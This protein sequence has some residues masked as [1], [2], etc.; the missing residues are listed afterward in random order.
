[1][2]KETMKMKAATETTFR[3]RARRGGLL[4]A[5]AGLLVLLAAAP[6]SAA[7]SWSIGM[8][9]KNLYGFGGLTSPYSGSGTSFARN[10]A[11]NGYSIQVTNSSL[12]VGTTL[13]CEN[14][15]W[16]G[17]T[18]FEYQWYRNSAPIA[19][20]TTSTYLTVAADVGKGLQCAVTGTNAGPGK[21][22]AY[23]APRVVG[24]PPTGGL[25]RRGEGQGLNATNS[26]NV[27]STLT[28]VPEFG[29]RWPTFTYQWL[30]NSAPIAGATNSTYT[31]QASDAPA[32]IQCAITATNAAG[33][34][35]V[36][37]PAQLTATA[38]SPT[39]PSAVVATAVA[40][41]VVNGPSISGGTDVAGGS[42]VGQKLTCTGGPAS[43]ATLAY[44]WLRNNAAI[45]GATSSTYTLV[46]A[47]AGT[48][49]Q[50]QVTATTSEAVSVK[51][52]SPLT[53]SP[54]PSTTP[55]AP[56]AAGPTVSGTANVGQVLTC[57]TG[58]WTGTSPTLTF[59][60][61][62]NGVAISGAT[63]STYTVA[64]SDLGANVQCQVSGENAG[65][66]ALQQSANKV[67][68][69]LPPSA[70]AAPTVSGTETVGGTLTCN[71][72][73]WAN[74]PSFGYEW[75]RNGAAISGATAQTYVVAIAD[76]GKVLQC[77]VT[78]ANS[79][80]TAQA[81]SA[82]TVVPPAPA[83]TPP[84]QSV[85]GSVSGTAE[86]GQVLTCA[87][88]TWSGGP[89]LSRQWLRNG[90]P[91]AGAIGETYTL[92]LADL[93]KSVQCQV[94]AANAGGASVAINATSGSVKPRRRRC[95]RPPR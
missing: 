69:A 72:G 6:A 61:L 9:H 34:V 30:K 62:H 25:P 83:T 7:P 53:V 11:G 23:T 76:E 91:I 79:Q 36:T 77:R 38:P 33:S 88:G 18:G 41:P 42:I 90:A 2:S 68:T 58:T 16:T 64:G 52:S 50:C 73:T 8:V 3:P 65:G 80:S 57:A 48:Q 67:I 54:P 20:A 75:L 87:T 59:Q 66:K 44:Q 22:I 51:E 40:T 86:V 27:G 29:W 13:T 17:A 92:T 71:N 56:P 46:A 4:L 45:A 82:N 43:G 21:F 32:A 5:A 81:V 85:A 35:T 12:A 24:A 14:G 74:G 63:S 28:C 78:A 95:R 49:V 1:M 15:T 89:V 55:P 37:T 39:A 93:G 31:I 26:G 19:G 84:S 10:S 70:S 60:W 94:T 47:D